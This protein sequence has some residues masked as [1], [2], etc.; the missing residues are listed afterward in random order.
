M[1]NFKYQQLRTTLANAI[2][3][4]IYLDKL[5]SV[6]ALSEQFNVSIATVQKAIEALERSG[7]VEA[8]PKRG[9]FICHNESRA[10]ASY[11]D[12]Y[13]L[14]SCRQEQ[15]RQVLF[16]LNDKTLM[17]LSSTAPSSIV[18]ISS[19]LGKL[20]RKVFDKSIYQYQVDDQLQGELSFRR[21]ISLFLHRQQHS[22]N[23][24]N[25]HITVGRRE[26]LV[27]ALAACKAI[28][29]TVAVES[30]TSF[31][32][33]AVINRLCQHVITVPMQTSYDKELELLDNAY[34]QHRFCV[35]LVNP[36]FNDSTGRVLKEQDKI[37]LLKWAAVRGVT[38]IEYDRSE[39][40][41]LADKPK[42]LAHLATTI[43]KASVISIQD[44]FDTVSSRINMGFILTV[45]M[46]QAVIDAKHTLTE[47]P[48]INSQ[49]LLN[50]LLQ[51]GEYE[52]HLAKLR[53]KLFEN[54][55]KAKQLLKTH[56]PK[57]CH[58]NNVS[59]GPCLWFFTP[60]QNSQQ[61]WHELIEQ[62]VAIAPGNMFSNSEEYKHFFRITFALPWNTELAKA[63]ISVCQAL[64]QADKNQ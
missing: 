49:M 55:S 29:A 56:L 7:L 46:R 31:Y 3:E 63:L 32:F 60:Y 14:V 47:G 4:G 16:S 45:N 61:I 36:S 43:S 51:S 21:N 15:E 20:Q 28:G 39:L 57:Q 34:Q 48:C 25:I 13:Q 40:Y 35:Y 12:N 22:I 42:S 41:F 5:P 11:G 37:K 27:V 6:R 54:Y 19:T 8:K 62:G 53:A 26:S 24:D 1:T 58:F 50:E 2:N 52:R 23:P 38:I 18:D 59:G 17:P 44:F 9:Y 10:V 30:P 64:A 33:Q